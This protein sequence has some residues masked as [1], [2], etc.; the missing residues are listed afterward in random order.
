MMEEPLKGKLIDLDEPATFVEPV[1]LKKDIKSAVEWLKIQWSK[2]YGNK[3]ISNYAYVR[4]EKLIGKAFP[5]LQKVKGKK[6]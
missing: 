5:D 4:F 1:A 3:K 6:K 2:D